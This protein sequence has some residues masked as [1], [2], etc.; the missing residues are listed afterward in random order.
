[1]ALN[2]QE[3]VQQT[4][5]EWE[6]HFT[7][8]PPED[9]YYCRDLINKGDA[10]V[11]AFPTD[12]I[13][14]AILAIGESEKDRLLIVL[15]LGSEFRFAKEPAKYLAM[16]AVLAKIGGCN[17]IASWAARMGTE[18]V[19]IQQGFKSDNSLGPRGLSYEVT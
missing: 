16:L 13:S 2:T 1:M 15:E 5:G 3:L 6:E 4:W 11:M 10:F 18:K 8:L 9:F 7:H 12:P 14:Y 19:L 17:R